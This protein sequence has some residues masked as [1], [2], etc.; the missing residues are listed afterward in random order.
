VTIIC[1]IDP[2]NMASSGA[3]LGDQKSVLVGT[4]VN[5]AVAIVVVAFR[6]IAKLKL[7]HVGSDDCAMFAALVSSHHALGVHLA[8]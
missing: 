1:Q 2:G 5:A 8:L 6:I 7:R 4:W 3:H